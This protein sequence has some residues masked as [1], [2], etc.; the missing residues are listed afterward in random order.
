MVAEHWLN[1][2]NFKVSLQHKRA[3]ATDLLNSCKAN[4]NFLIAKKDVSLF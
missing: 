2:G 3:S 4:F 1:S